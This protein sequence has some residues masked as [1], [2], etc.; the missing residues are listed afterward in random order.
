ILKNQ[1][2]IINYYLFNENFVF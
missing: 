2:K 1:F